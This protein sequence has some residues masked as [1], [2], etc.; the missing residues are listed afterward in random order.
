MQLPFKICIID[1]KIRKVSWKTEVL[2]MWTVVTENTCSMPQ[3]DS[4]SFSESLGPQ[5]QE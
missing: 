5:I 1:I 2:E 3:E 4:S